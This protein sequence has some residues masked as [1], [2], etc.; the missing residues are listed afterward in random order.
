MDNT[1][2]TLMTVNKLFLELSYPHWN[3]HVLQSPVLQRRRRHFYYKRS[4][5]LA[6]AYDHTER[7]QAKSFVRFHSSLGVS[8]Y[9]FT[10]AGVN[11]FVG[12]RPCALGHEVGAVY[13]WS[14]WKT[15]GWTQ[16]WWVKNNTNEEIWRI[17][18]SHDEQCEELWFSVYVRDSAGNI[19]WDSNDG[20]NYSVDLF[21]LN[22][23]T[24]EVE[25]PA[26]LQYEQ[27]K[28][29]QNNFSYEIC[30]EL[31]M[32]PNATEICC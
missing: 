21:A 23:T 29:S 7:A 19:V 1:I 12:V 24:Y 16:G 26:I 14:K 32:S 25:H 9:G 27:N 8:A 3:T 2:P 11:I 20:W 18:I 10:S 28:N 6:V 5:T 4:N 22:T 17:N 31:W 13:T 30:E 15:E